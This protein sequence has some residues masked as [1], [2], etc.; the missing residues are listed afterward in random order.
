MR[1]IF[2]NNTNFVLL[3]KDNQIIVKGL[4]FKGYGELVESFLWGYFPEDYTDYE[5]KKNE[6]MKN[7]DKKLLEVLHYLES[8]K[9]K[10]GKF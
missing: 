4:F 3:A 7:K 5:N 2:R 6:L 10:T 9:P 8:C 1:G